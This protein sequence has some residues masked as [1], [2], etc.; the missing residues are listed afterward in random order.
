MLPC[1]LV[2]DIKLCAPLTLCGSE[3]QC[4]QSLKYLGVQFVA[5]KK[6]TCSVDNVNVKFYRTFNAIYSRSK[7]IRDYYSYLK[8]IVYHSCYSRL[9]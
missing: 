5:A 7:G 6:L 3:L 8:R 1:V 9:K 4:V 2:N